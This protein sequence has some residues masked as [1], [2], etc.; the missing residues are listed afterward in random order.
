MRSSFR[1]AE[2]THTHI[3]SEVHVELDPS[4]LSRYRSLTQIVSKTFNGQIWMI[5]FD[6]VTFYS[7]QR[8][9]WDKVTYRSY[10][11]LFSYYGWHDDLAK[12]GNTVLRQNIIFHLWRLANTSFTH[13]RRKRLLT[14][15]VN[16][17]AEKMHP[18]INFGILAFPFDPFYL[19][20][21]PPSR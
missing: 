5:N 6:N 16:F 11:S 4:N 8:T 1:H 14:T 13:V 21:M 2:R 12:S 18:K 10:A 19:S 3:K 9:F 20:Q 15:T 7:L 17:A